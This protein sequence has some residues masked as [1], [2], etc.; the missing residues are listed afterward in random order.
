[1][2]IKI[3]DFC[4]IS[5]SLRLRIIDEYCKIY[6]NSSL[7]DDKSMFCLNETFN[8][9][10]TIKYPVKVEINYSNYHVKCRKTK[11]SYVFDIWLAS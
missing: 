3:N 1:M 8:I 2:N 7:N 5:H 9:K 4:V 10:E 11:T 6:E